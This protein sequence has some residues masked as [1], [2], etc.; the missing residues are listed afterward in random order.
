MEMLRPGTLKTSDFLPVAA[1]VTDLLSKMPAAAG[2]IEP[3]DA[4]VRSSLYLE[5]GKPQTS[6]RFVAYEAE[7]DRLVL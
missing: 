2:T 5:G 6:A 7:P 3:S 1:P 4:Q